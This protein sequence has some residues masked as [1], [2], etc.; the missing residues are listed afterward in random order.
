MDLYAAMAKLDPDIRALLAMRYVAGFD[1]NELAK[2]TGISPS[3]TR[4]RIER[5][6][7]SGRISAMDDMN[8][9]ERQVVGQIQTFVGPSRPVDD[10]AIFTA[11]SAT[12]ARKWGILPRAGFA[13]P[14]DARAMATA[15]SGAATHE[16]RFQTMLS[17]LK[18]V[19]AAL[20]TLW[21]AGGL[22]E[23]GAVD[24]YERARHQAII[25]PVG[26]ELRG[27]L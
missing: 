20:V 9:F 11:I 27:Q 25:H 3:G 7:G 12:Q 26:R 18:F 17:A 21:C 5:V 15:A 16:W 6:Y 23:A 19:V 10:A 2:A 1:S 8:A 22:T 4:S 13:R 14:F 24:E